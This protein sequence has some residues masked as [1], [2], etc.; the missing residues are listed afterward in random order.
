MEVSFIANGMTPSE[1]KRRLEDE[2]RSW[3]MVGKG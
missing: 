2:M 1:L 3:E